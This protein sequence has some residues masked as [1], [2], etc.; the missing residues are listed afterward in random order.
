MNSYTL[1]IN[2]IFSFGKF[3]HSFGNKYNGKLSKVFS[4]DVGIKN[5]SWLRRTIETFSAL[6]ASFLIQILLKELGRNPC[7]NLCTN[8]S[9]KNSHK[10]GS[11]RHSSN[12]NYKSSLY[13]IEHYYGYTLNV[14]GRLYT[15]NRKV[16]ISKKR[17]EN[18]ET[19]LYFNQSRRQSIQQFRKYIIYLFRNMQTIKWLKYYYTKLL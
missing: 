2:L 5:S 7:I 14:T 10:L 3:T 12:A 17:I 8:C 9:L 11:I 16:F 1:R 19:K 6:L 13:E 4:L 15:H 18:T